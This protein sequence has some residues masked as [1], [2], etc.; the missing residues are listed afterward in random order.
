MVAIAFTLAR[1]HFELSAGEVRA[2]LA[3]HRPDPID[4]YWVEIDDVRWPVK[5]VMVLATG[6]GKGDFQSQNSRRL[7]AKLGFTIGEGNAA[8]APPTGSTTKSRTNPAP[9]ARSHSSAD[10][11]L[12]GCVKSKR[13]RGGAAK[14]LYTSDYF[15][16]M[17][18]YAENTGRPW[19]IRACCSRPSCRQ[20]MVWSVP[21]R[22]LNRMTA[23]CPT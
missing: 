22:G 23:I 15:A 6:L 12:V 19:L 10:V 1:Q 7:L 2:R 21:R 9:S 11:V 17:R 14:D 20:S 4:Q 13:T 5:Q 18:A 8:L 3:Q 16:K